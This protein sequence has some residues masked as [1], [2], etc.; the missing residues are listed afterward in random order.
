M[1]CCPSSHHHTKFYCQP[2]CL[3]L[4]CGEEDNS[5]HQHSMECEPDYGVIVNQDGSVTNQ[6]SGGNIGVPTDLQK[7][8]QEHIDDGCPPN[9]YECGEEAIWVD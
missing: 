2:S 8:I 4:E 1:Y 9:C 3:P 5:N 6:F 7:Y